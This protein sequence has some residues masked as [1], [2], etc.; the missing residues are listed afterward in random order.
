MFD[1]T[2]YK[3]KWQDDMESYLLCHVAAILPIGYLSYICGGNLR[4]STGGQRKMMLEA[5]H[6]A[7][8]FLKDRGITIYPV[9]DDKYFEKGIRKRLMGLLYFVMAKTKIGELAACEHCRNAVSEMEQLDLFYAE[10]MEEYPAKKLQVWR[11]LRSQM[12]SW[13]ELHKRY[14]N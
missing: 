5:S 12:P 3:L 10:L 7:Y 6:E 11:R 13:E 1:G 4:K 14:G 9:N 2:D 8:E